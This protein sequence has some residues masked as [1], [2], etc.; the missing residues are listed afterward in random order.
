MR[1]LGQVGED[2]ERERDVEALVE[3]QPVGDEGRLRQL[4]RH[5]RVA[6]GVEDRRHRVA[7]VQPPGRDVP[8][9]IPREPAPAAAEVEHPRLG[10]RARRRGVHP[11]TQAAVERRALDGQ[12]RA[13]GAVPQLL[14][15]RVRH[16]GQQ[17]AEVRPVLVLLG[18]EQRPDVVVELAE[19]REP[20]RAAVGAA[21]VEP[22]ELPARDRPQPGVV[23]PVR[24]D[25]RR[26][27]RLP[28][29][30][31]AEPQDIGAAAE[32][33]QRARDAPAQGGLVVA[34]DHVELRRGAGIRADRHP[35]A[36]YWR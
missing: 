29:G 6:T 4:G 11:L 35:R 33:P 21:R 3:R 13:A 5:A 7:A 12:A 36:G 28:P 15:R 22:V 19:Q 14:E 34:A 17:R 2:G 10:E 30:P 25:R 8:G 23:A 24:E 18:Q 31:P 16:R 26:R 9:E 27:R 1:R 20:V 32:R